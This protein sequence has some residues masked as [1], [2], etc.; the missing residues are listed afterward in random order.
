MVGLA[1][2]FA[3]VLVVIGVWNGLGG[4]ELLGVLACIGA[5]SCYGIAFPYTRRH[6]AG[7]GEGPISIATG[8]VLLGALFLLPVVVGAELVGGGRRRGAGEHGDDPRDARPGLARV[9][10]RVR[11]Q[12]PG[13]DGR[14]A[15]R[16]QAR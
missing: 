2:G 16:S 13:A 7:S 8:Q 1:I 14:R 9:G 5:I 6:L 10:D 11:P 3:G 15:R 12:H 4:G